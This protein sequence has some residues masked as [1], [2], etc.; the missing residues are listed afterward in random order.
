V[1]CL[2]KHSKPQ[3]SRAQATPIPNPTNKKAKMPSDPT[4]SSVYVWGDNKFGQLGTGSKSS[5]KQEEGYKFRD[6]LLADEF[7][8][9]G[10]THVAAGGHHTLALDEF[11][12]PWAC[13]RNKEGQLG[14]GDRID[15]TA[16]ALI[17]TGELA[18]HVCKYVACGSSSSA[19]VTQHGA[20]FEWGLMHYIP[21]AI[22][23]T[24]TAQ[25]QQGNND[26]SADDAGPSMAMPGLTR[27]GARP[28]S[29]R[30]AKLLQD[31]TM[32]YLRVSRRSSSSTGNANDPNSIPENEQANVSDTE[33]AAA[34]SSGYEDDASDDLN[35]DDVEAGVQSVRTRRRPCV[36]PVRVKELG[37]VYVSAIAFGYGHTLVL[38]SAGQVFSKGYNDRGQLGIGSRMAFVEYQRVYFT[39]SGDPGVERSAAHQRLLRQKTEGQVEG[40]GNSS[41]YAVDAG[42][43]DDD[44]KIVSIACGSS[45]NLCLAEDGRVFVFGGN[46]LGQLGLGPGR[47][48]QMLPRYNDLLF[49]KCG[50]CKVL[51]CGSNHS[52]V[53]S[54]EG[55]LFSWGHS[56]YGQ[57]GGQVEGG[58]DLAHGQKI[59]FYH[60]PR[61]VRPFVAG[62]PKLVSLACGYLFNLAQDAFG[63][64]WSWGWDSHG[65]LGLGGELVLFCDYICVRLRFYLCVSVL[66]GRICHA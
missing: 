54:E 32:K 7:E 34:G 17:A 4:A 58:H 28:V 12:N 23:D 45:H 56:E 30:L 26:G 2:S 37:A 51:A 55:E 41:A 61:E 9:L 24:A 66:H 8:P 33:T 38:T 5:A 31:S 53:I 44:L 3:L 46:S 10:V 65:A 6:P 22:N 15:R 25:Q 42:T 39:L 20:L 29:D 60:S 63:R 62:G 57:H 64:V 27:G 36:E 18:G 11:G 14:L 1:D 52:A 49:D 16:P 50:R 21:A 43:S 59:K 48:D 13:G 35:P 40:G 47:S 19:V